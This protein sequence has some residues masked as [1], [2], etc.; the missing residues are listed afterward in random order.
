M[1]FTWKGEKFDTE[2][3]C[4]L[5]V[6]SLCEHDLYYF[7]TEILDKRALYP[8]LHRDK[9]IPFLTEWKEDVFIKHLEL[10]RAHLKSTI[11]SIGFP[12]WIWGLDPKQHDFMC[13]TEARFLLGHAN[14]KDAK[15]FLKE[16]KDI[17][18]SN[19]LY[20]WLYPE[21]VFEN[22][23]RDSS[24]W[25]ADAY[26]IKR[27]RPDKTASM[28]ACGIGALPVGFH[29]H[30]L[31]MDDLVGRDNVKTAA[32]RDDTMEF[33]QDVQDLI[34]GGCKM[35]VPGTRWHHDDLYSHLLDETGRFADICE[36]LVLDC[37]WLAGEPIF[38]ISE[39]VPACG[40]SMKRLEAK[41]KS[42][43]KYSFM[44]QYMNDPQPDAENSFDR[45][46]F[47]RFRFDLSDDPKCSVPTTRNYHFVTACDPN[48]GEKEAN[49][50][51]AVITAAIDEEGE[52]WVVDIS[53]GKYSPKVLVDVI[54]Q[55][56]QKWQS[57]TTVIETTGVGLPIYTEVQREMI[58]RKIFFDLKEAKRGGPNS[59]IDRIRTMIPLCEREGIHVLLGGKLY[60]EL[61]E[62]LVNLGVS[63]N[64]DMADATADIYMYGERPRPKK[65]ER[66]REAPNSQFMLKHLLADASNRSNQGIVTLIE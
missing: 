41:L 14:L 2:E 22:F 18:Q 16:S 9:V 15:M 64:D 48:R 63:K 8:P 35:I 44:C 47:Q 27:D 30:W 34:L 29:Y 32:R 33:F 65:Q 28:S 39:K 46:D 37:G 4:R 62:E 25:T 40:W 17:L 24:T 55:H 53:S 51:A 13:G 12:L 20:R 54:I 26:T 5:H 1:A 21:V 50:P 60:D 61:I 42:K 66:K 36:S 6:R 52:L 59:K 58:V 49:D 7:I 45:D 10:P 57:V 31:I 23:K 56:Q 43:G 3:E 11:V 38:P 19:D